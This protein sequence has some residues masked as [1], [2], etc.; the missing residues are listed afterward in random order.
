MIPT[1]TTIQPSPLERTHNPSTAPV[2]HHRRNVLPTH[3]HS[4]PQVSLNRLRSCGGFRCSTAQY[5]KPRTRVRTGDTFHRSS[6]SVVRQ[7][8][9][10]RSARLWVFVTCPPR[11]KSPTESGA[12]RNPWRQPPLPQ[13]MGC[14]SHSSVAE[15][16]CFRRVGQWVGGAL[17]THKWGLIGQGVAVLFFGEGCF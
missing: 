12:R 4:Q 15:R 2:C 9:R 6:S 14:P 11:A 16:P 7:S 10:T 5:S 17:V 3:T 13:A 1:G 8:A